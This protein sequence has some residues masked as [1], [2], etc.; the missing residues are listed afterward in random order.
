LTLTL[1]F[2]FRASRRSALDRFCGDLS[3][4]IYAVHLTVIALVEQFRWQNVASTTVLTIGI[5]ASLALVLVVFLERPIDR[6]RHSLSSARRIHAPIGLGLVIELLDDDDA[7][8]ASRPI[9][10]ATATSTTAAN[11]YA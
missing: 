2:L 5:T 10:T 9:A 8:S 7:G 11:V 6:F 1:P 4:P 3:Y